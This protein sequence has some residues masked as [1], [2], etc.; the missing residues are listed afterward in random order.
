[1]KQAVVVGA[2]FGGIAAALRMRAKGYAV[3]LLDKQG[4]L[5][6]RARTFEKEGYLFDAGPT[7]VTAPFLFDELFTLFDKYR[8]DYIKFVPV[9]PWYRFEYPDGDHFNYG[10]TVEDTLAEIERIAPEDKDG[11]LRLLSASKDIFDVG[12]TELADKPFHEFSSMLSQIPNLMRLK[13]YKSVWQLICDHLK[14]DKIRQAFS[15]QPL[16]VGGNP[17]DTTCIYNLIH[18]LEREWGIHFAL[19]GTGAIV[20]GLEVLMREQ[21]IRIELNQDVTEFVYQNKQVTAVKCANGSEFSCDMLVSNMDPSYL[22]KKIIPKNKQALSAKIKTATAKHSM[23]L[24]VLYF[25]TD[26]TYPDVAHHT[27]WLGKRYRELLNDIFDKKVLADDF[28]LYVHRPTATD[29]S[30]APKGCDSFYV[31]A[32]VPNLQGGQ[33]WDEIG[34]QYAQRIL[35]A[36]D[37]TM[38]PGVKEHVTVQFHKAPNDFETDYHAMHGSGFSIAPSLTQSAWFR[39]HNKAEGLNNVILTGAGTHPGAGM[40]GVLCSAKVIEHLVEPITEKAPSTT[41][42]LN[43]SHGIR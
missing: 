14:N 24:F 11:Y 42:E 5:G 1:M 15:I 41:S 16:L 27:I 23:G 21:G 38:L 9:E 36:L 34:D 35:D 20:K 2:G 33:D 12:F 4:Q 40:P 13:S 19:G 10:G 29:A 31:L 32:P 39:Y 17:F 28:S 43:L 7:V 26:N 6:G 3:T 8:E 37:K 30:F 25:G 22:Y 18:F